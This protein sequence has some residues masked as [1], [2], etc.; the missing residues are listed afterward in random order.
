MSY[1]LWL[2]GAVLGCLGLLSHA[3]DY[4]W[5]QHVKYSMEVDLDVNSHQFQ[6]TQKLIYTNNSPDTLNRVFYHL[7][8][9]AFQ[10]GSMMDVRSRTISD[11][12]SRVGKRIS[13]LKESEIGYLRVQSLS[14][15][16]QP[17]EYQTEG[18]ILEVELDKPLY[19][20]QSTTFDMSFNG[21]V[22]LQIRRSGRDN[23]EGISYSMSQWYPKLAE[24]DHM[25]WHANPYIGRE[26]HGVW[27]DFELR[28]KIDKNYVVA[29]TGHLQNKAQVDPQ[30][31]K[32]ICTSKLKR[33][34]TLYGQLIRTIVRYR[35]RCRMA[36]LYISITN[37]EK[38][39]NTGRSFRNIPSELFSMSMSTTE[40]TLM[41][42]TVSF[43]QVTVVWSIPWPH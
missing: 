27:G 42:S 8:F 26:F 4:R 32:A 36:L 12:D 40:N 21:Q 23:E 2:I 28:L 18:T 24:Y 41:K 33:Y 43:R 7:Y 29:A 17:L 34:T 35:P 15:D 1:K 9:N 31:S 5:Q 22:P 14:Q 39:L 13:K 38:K 16:Q 37:L 6:G 11:P 20:G 3:Q 25:G 10:P 19:P 30:S